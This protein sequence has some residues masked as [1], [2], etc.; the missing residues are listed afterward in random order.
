MADRTHSTTP[1]REV[2]L[3]AAVAAANAEVR[4]QGAAPGQ[5]P[6]TNDTYWAARN[7]DMLD[8]YARQYQADVAARAVKA[9]LAAPAAAQGQVLTLLG[10]TAYAGLPPDALGPVLS[11]LGLANFLALTPGDQ[12]ECFTLAALTA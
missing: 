9:F 8:S 3:S 7:D 5:T 2:A 1:L 10:L 12:N 4:A 11:T 6:W